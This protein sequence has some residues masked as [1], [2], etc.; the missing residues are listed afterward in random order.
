MHIDDLSTDKNV[1]LAISQ[2]LR[3]T[4]FTK[5]F[6]TTARRQF[7]KFGALDYRVAK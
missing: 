4:A 7:F 3:V 1:L 2:K 5:C 6:R